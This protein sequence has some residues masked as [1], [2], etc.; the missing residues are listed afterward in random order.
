MQSLVKSVVFHGQKKVAFEDFPYD[1]RP[2]GPG[3]LTGR[4]L[5][6]LISPGTELNSAFERVRES[7]A[8]G[9]Y[10]AIIEVDVVGADVTSVQPGDRVFM[11]GG[12]RA[13][14]RGRAVDA[15]PIPAGLPSEVAVFCRLAGVSWTTLVTTRARP[16]EL[17]VVF[18]LGIVGNLAAQIFHAGGYRV[19]AVDVNESRCALARK[20]GLPDARTAIAADDTAIR[21]NAAIVIDCS[22]HEGVALEGCRIVRKGGEVVLIGVPWKK[23]SDASAF[24]VMHAVF[25]KYA[26][27]RSGWEWSVPNQPTD[28]VTGSIRD[29]FAGA[30][31]WL[32]AGRLKV[33]G[34]AQV[35]SPADAQRVYD[36]LLTQ[37]FPT[38]SAIFDWTKV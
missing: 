38:L 8:V 32:A 7:P 37:S 11:Q 30:I 16:A 18:G 1:V 14:H 27:L 5:M 2:P 24:D 33:D 17:V 19:V 31:Q 20:L 29:N 21:G 35:L 12:H 25:H 9:G 23:R 26:T 36:E 13:R 4:T 10:A 3:E 28:F 22:G 15:I 34:L 6:T